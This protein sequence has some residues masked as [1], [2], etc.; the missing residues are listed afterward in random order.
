MIDLNQVL[1]ALHG[2][3]ARSLVILDEFGKGTVASGESKVI[4]VAM[5]TRNRSSWLLPSFW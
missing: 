2:A 3:T 1:P 4:A 5:L